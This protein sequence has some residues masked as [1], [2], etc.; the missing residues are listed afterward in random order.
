MSDVVRRVE[1]LCDHFEYLDRLMET[2]DGVVEGEAEELVTFLDSASPEAFDDLDDY[3][4][5]CEAT[6]K[7]LKERAAALKERADLYEARKKRARA[8]ALSLLRKMGTE[9]VRTPRGLLVYVTKGAEIV[10]KTSESDPT[11]LPKDLCRRKPE[12]FEE[13]LRAIL[14]ALKDG[15]KDVPP[16]YRLGRGDEKVTFK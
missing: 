16:W 13:D 14:K 2:S 12:V 5:E 6:A 15:R 7:A 3:I 11:L 1:R 4:G 8:I 10:E 9:K